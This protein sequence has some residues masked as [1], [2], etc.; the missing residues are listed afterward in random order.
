MRS[1]VSWLDSG[2]YG[3]CRSEHPYIILRVPNADLDNCIVKVED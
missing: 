1:R 3:Y 2:V